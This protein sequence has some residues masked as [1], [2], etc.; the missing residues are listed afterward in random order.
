M[1]LF[2]NDK[3]QGRDAVNA[4]L[5]LLVLRKRVVFEKTFQP[6]FN[7]DTDKRNKLWIRL[8]GAGM[9]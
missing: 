2:L 8:V 4:L 1:W 6:G 9:L 5:S 7:N 3:D